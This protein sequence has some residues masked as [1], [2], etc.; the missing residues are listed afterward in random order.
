MS[1]YIHKDLFRIFPELHVGILVC[2]NIQAGSIGHYLEKQIDD[3]YTRNPSLMALP[4]MKA[5]REAY[6]VLGVKKGVRVSIENLS[7]RVIKGKGLPS[8][9]SL[10]DLYNAVSLKYTFPCGGED[11]DAIKGDVHLTFATG[12]EHFIA[13]GSDDIEPPLPNEVVYIDDLG[14]LCRRFNWREAD[15]T[16]LTESTENAILVI[17]SLTAS[18]VEQLQ[19]ALLEMKYFLEE[20]FKA[21]VQMRILNTKHTYFEFE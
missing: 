10:V 2:K 8:I 1:L 6:K 13:I 18:R 4:E 14:C 5:W 12:Q 7:K 15:R 3:L 19:A 9:N 20:D 16:K 21:D 11:L 17:E